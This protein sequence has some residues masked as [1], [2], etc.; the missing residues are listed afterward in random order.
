VQPVRWHRGRVTN[1]GELGGAYGHTVAIDARGTVA[2]QASADDGRHGLVWTRNSVID[3]GP[4]DLGGTNGSVLAMNDRG[5]V[6][7][8]VATTGAGAHACSGI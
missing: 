3:L 6:V 1:L 5:L 4:I 7:G 8:A 2:G